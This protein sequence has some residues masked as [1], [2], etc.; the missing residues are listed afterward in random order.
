MSLQ[1]KSMD[2]IVIIQMSNYNDRY[3]NHHGEG[4]EEK[5]E[6][7]FSSSYGADNFYGTANTAPPPVKKQQETYQEYESEY[8]QDNYEHDGYI[9]AEEEEEESKL[10]FAFYSFFIF[11]CIQAIFAIQFA[12]STSLLA[13][14]IAMFI[15][16]FTY[17]VNLFAVKYK[18]NLEE[19]RRS[20]SRV[21]S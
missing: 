7:S 8:D 11:T 6:F 18:R 19:I 15:D 20:Q 17:L 14:T 12:H 10:N 1:H 5:E 2:S 9:Y 21:E 13:D 4:Q 16:S 3:V